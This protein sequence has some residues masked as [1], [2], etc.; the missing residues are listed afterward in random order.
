[1]PSPNTQVTAFINQQMANANLL[2]Q[3]INQQVVLDEQWTANGYATIMAAMTTAP[4]NA[5]GTQNAANPDASPV[6]THPFSL[7]AYPN[8]NRVVTPTQITQI[9]TE[10]DK[11]VSFYNGNALSADAAF[12]GILN[13]VVGG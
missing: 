7:T 6:E 4:L 1:M 10:L 13:A 12:A 11:L 9:K 3:I 8:I 5:D 2:V